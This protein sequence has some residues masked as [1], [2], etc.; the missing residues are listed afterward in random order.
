MTM[1][2]TEKTYFTSLTTQIRRVEPFPRQ[3]E[4]KAF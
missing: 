4:E 1:A 2:A 3:I